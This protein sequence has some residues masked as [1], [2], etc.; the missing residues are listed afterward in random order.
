MRVWENS[1]SSFTYYAVPFCS[2]AY[3]EFVLF[4]RFTFIMRGYER[5][6]EVRLSLEWSGMRDGR[7]SDIAQEVIPATGD[8]WSLRYVCF[9]VPYLEDTLI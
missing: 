9:Y 7:D 2:L 3:S 6:R 5:Y 4:F 1:K 8:S